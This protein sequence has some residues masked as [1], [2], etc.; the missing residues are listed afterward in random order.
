MTR[1]DIVDSIRTLSRIHNTKPISDTDIQ[2]IIERAI[3]DFSN[4]CP[5]CIG[6]DRGNSV[7]DQQEYVVCSDYLEI[8]EVA[9]MDASG[10]LLATTIDDNDM[11]V[12]AATDISEFASSGT[13]RIE[14]E[15]LTYSSKNDGTKTFTISARGASSTTATAHTAGVGVIAANQSYLR[16]EPT[17][18][19][20][21]GDSD[22]AWLSVTSGIPTSYYFFPG[23]MG[24]DLP[25][26]KT[27]YHN[28]LIRAF[29]RPPALTSDTSIITGLIQ[30]FN[31]AIVNYGVAKVLQMLSQ[32]EATAAMGSRYWGDYISNVSEF[33]KIKH[34]YVRGDN[35]GITPYT[36]RV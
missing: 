10:V 28:I 18:P 9:Y 7:K 20:R 27:G 30:T 3:D 33:K 17:S 31:Q 19:R 4:K 22:S 32:D 15:L 11:A 14:N 23:V 2:I 6:I 12:V 13:L 26:S 36:G 21:L 24:F 5:F 1:A 35:P 29:V 34:L 8:I 16:L 25:T